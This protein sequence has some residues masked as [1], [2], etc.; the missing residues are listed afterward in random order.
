MPQICLQRN[1]LNQTFPVKGLFDTR[2]KN[3][4]P[5]P[6][7]EKYVLKAGLSNRPMYTKQSIE[8][9]LVCTFKMIPNQKSLY[10]GSTN[11]LLR[12]STS[13]SGK[14]SINFSL[15]FVFTAACWQSR[16]RGQIALTKSS[17]IFV[18]KTSVLHFV[19]TVTK[20]V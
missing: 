13:S 18:L 3:M 4:P 11:L 20:T 15:T 10:V 14:F 1:W 9:I 12:S 17:Y 7:L 2:H 19:N 8:N 16:K 5:P 6:I